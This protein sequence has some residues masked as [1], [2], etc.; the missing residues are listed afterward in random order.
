MGGG[1]VLHVARGGGLVGGHV[2]NSVSKSVQIDSRQY[3]GQCRAAARI[4]SGGCS[5]KRT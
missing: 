4:A 3:V 5:A 2:E 1:S